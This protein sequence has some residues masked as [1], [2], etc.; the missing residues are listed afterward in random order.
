MAKKTAWIMCSFVVAVSM[1]TWASP[2][3]SDNSASARATTVSRSASPT[4]NFTAPPPAII[5]SPRYSRS[6]SSSHWC[7]ATA[8]SALLDE[9]DP[10]IGPF[11]A[12]LVVYDDAPHPPPAEGRR[13]KLEAAAITGSQVGPSVEQPQIA[14]ELLDR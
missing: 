8:I 11:G 14:A 13:R 1:A 10:D 2:R 5:K 6:I 9:P 7:A 3:R 12:S 4:T